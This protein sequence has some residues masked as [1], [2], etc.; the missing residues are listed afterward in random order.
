MQ[1]QVNALTAFLGLGETTLKQ[2]DEVIGGDG[3]CLLIAG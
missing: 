2:V 1:S 3:L